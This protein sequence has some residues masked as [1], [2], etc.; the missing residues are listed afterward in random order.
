LVPPPPNSGEGTDE[1]RDEDMSAIQGLERL[2]AVEEIIT[3]QSRRVRAI[4]T[5]DWKLYKAC[6][7]ADFVSYTMNAPI[8]GIDRVVEG[9]SVHLEGVRTSHMVTSPEIIFASAES[10]SGTWVLHDRLWWEQDGSPHWCVGWGFYNDT[11]AK[12]DGHWLFTSRKIIR[13]RVETSPGA[14]LTG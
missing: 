11:Y 2:L 10:A 8:K 5:Q 3:L 12:R 9:L 14:R 13:T 1:A 4:D 6:H 7:T